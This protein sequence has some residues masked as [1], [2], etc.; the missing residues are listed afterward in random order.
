[1]AVGGGPD[2]ADLA[3]VRGP[4]RTTDGQPDQPNPSPATGPL[5]PYRRVWDGRQVAPDEN[6]LPAT[7]ISHIVPVQPTTRRNNI[8]SYSTVFVTTLTLRCS[9]TESLH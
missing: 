1:M 2:R 6:R 5:P 3:G 4:G 8:I 9:I 7:A